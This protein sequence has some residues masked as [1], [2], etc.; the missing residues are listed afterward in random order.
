MNFQWDPDKAEINPKKHRVDF[1]DAVAVF[2]DEMAL[3]IERTLTPKGSLG[4]TV[5]REALSRILTVVYTWRGQDVR[6]IS[7]RKATKRERQSYEEEL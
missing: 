7:A 2:E 1:A 3:T 5:G 4:S 6:I